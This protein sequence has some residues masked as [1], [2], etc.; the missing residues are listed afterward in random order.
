MQLAKKPV[1]PWNVL[2]L[3]HKGIVHVSLTCEIQSQK[4][5][6]L[7]QVPSA[8]DAGDWKQHKIFT[9]MQL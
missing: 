4:L 1:L 5:R 7:L 2:K 8:A 6:A 3:S 9:C